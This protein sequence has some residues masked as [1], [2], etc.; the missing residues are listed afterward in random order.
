MI[1]AID[2]PA[3]VGK[4]TAARRLAARLGFV[5]L[6]TGALYRAVTWKACQEG[7]PLERT[8]EVLRAWG[9]SQVD[10]SGGPDGFRV[11]LDG[12]D[13]SEELRLPEVERNV[14]RLA[15]EPRVREAL[16]SLQREFARDRDVVAEGRD[17]GTV[18]FPG[19]E[20]KFYLDADL[21]ERAQRRRKQREKAGLASDESQVLG[22][23]RERD[24]ADRLREISP[25]KQAE[26]SICI[27]TTRL[28]LDE[29]VQQMAERV[30]E[31]RGAG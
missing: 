4:S 24:E 6:D 29:V 2:G 15:G 16:V 26:D 7:I 31:R 1:V 17:T 11:L 20:L 21:G 28:T 18:V 23:I 14:R 19:A 10:L 8:D 27:N 13:I 22:E 12:R 30:A 5:F 25:L 9:G 3:G